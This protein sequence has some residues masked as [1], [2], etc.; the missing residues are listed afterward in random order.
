MDIAPAAMNIRHRSPKSPQVFHC[1]PAC[2]SPDCRKHGSYVRKGFH[3]RTR[4]PVIRVVPRYR[5]LNSQCPRRTFS[6][7][8]PGVLRYCRFLCPSLL[9]LKAA[10]NNGISAC[11]L[12]LRWF[13]G[14]RVIAYAM[15]QLELMGCFADG[16]YRELADGAAAPQLPL[17]VK[18]LVAKIG[19][20]ALNWRWYCHRYPLRAV[21]RKDAT[22]FDSFL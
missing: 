6:I 22:Q 2:N 14:R 7:L 4:A 19:Y 12:A 15:S 10:R 20:P 16:L 3:S 9:S 1:C 13:T 8:P 21:C 17:T 11:R 18:F 5:C